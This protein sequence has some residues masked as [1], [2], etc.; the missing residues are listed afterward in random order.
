MVDEEIKQQI[1]DIIKDRT[2]FRSRRVA[3]ELNISGQMIGYIFREMEK[4]GL[5]ERW[6]INQ[7][8]W[9]ET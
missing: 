6:S 2:F 1:M 4:E 7:W 5:I 3:K 9:R 8:R